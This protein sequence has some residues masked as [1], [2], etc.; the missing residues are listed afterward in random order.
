R[1]PVTSIGPV[2]PDASRAAGLSATGASLL[3]MLP[4]L[5]FGVFSPLAPRMS[6][7]LGVERAVLAALVMLVAG[8]A[9]RGAGGAAGLFAGQILGCGGIG[10]INVLL[11]SLVKRD[12][13][14]R[15][16]FITGLYVMAM[17]VGAA[18]AAGATVPLERLLGSWAAALSLWA[19]PAL[20]AT[21]IWL[22]QLAAPCEETSVTNHRL[23]GLWSDRLAWQVTLF[24]GLQSALAYIVFGWLAPILRD[25]GFSPV[26]AGLA[27][28]IS[29]VAQAVASLVAPSLATLGKDQ[30]PAVA[31]LS[32]LCM[33]SLL[34]CL[35][36]PLGSVWVWS[37]LL[38]FSQGGLFPIALMLI[39]L[40]APDANMTRHLSGMAQGVGYILASAGPLLAGLL[41]ASMGNWTGLA[42]LVVGLG[43][44]MLLAGLGAGRGR[45]IKAGYRS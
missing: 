4:A 20:I 22:P 24:M 31:A 43:V 26:E 17:S 28:S 30:R 36:A 16:A 14:R 19:V 34:G 29:I 42:A 25:R 11:P 45:H 7:F 1:T 18:L 40:R 8:T 12:F 39:V 9:L 6:R 44:A 32:L 23:R 21:L 3:T 41:H 35:Y 5:C 15:V 37:V 10:V 27:L 13:P 33:V 2:L 38:G